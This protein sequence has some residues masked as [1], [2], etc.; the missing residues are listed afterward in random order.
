MGLGVCSSGHLWGALCCSLHAFST[1]GRDENGWT[2][3]LSL[4]DECSHRLSSVSPYR[5]EINFPI[6]VP[7]FCLNPA[8]TLPMSEPLYLR[9]MAAFPNSWG[10]IHTVPPGEG[11]ASFASLTL[12]STQR[13]ALQFTVY[14]RTLVPRPAA[15]DRLPNS[16]TWEQC[17]TWMPSVF[18]A[19]QGILRPPCHS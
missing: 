19:T 16:Y 17:S 13:T 14:S 6:C 18:P 4:R 11:L 5:R 8:F 7:D 10:S 1:D 12:E 15:R 3:L 2:L 9:H